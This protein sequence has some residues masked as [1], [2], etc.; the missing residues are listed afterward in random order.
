MSDGGVQEALSRD[1]RPLVSSRDCGAEQPPVPHV[2]RASLLPPCCPQVR[3]AVLLQ[4]CC[5]SLPAFSTLSKQ[6]EE[7]QWCM[8]QGCDFVQTCINSPAGA[9]F[10]L[11]LAQVGLLPPPLFPWAHTHGSLLALHVCPGLGVL[12]QLGLLLPLWHSYLS[13]AGTLVCFFSTPAPSTLIS[14]YCHCHIPVR[15]QSSHC[16]CAV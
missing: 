14:L 13:Q 3:S 11:Q 10:L 12:G 6:E 16:Y 7:A 15:A 1:R 9:L 8:I 4:C 5:S 2:L